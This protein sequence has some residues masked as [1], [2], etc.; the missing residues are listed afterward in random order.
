MKKKIFLSI[1]LLTLI[2][3]GDS[4]YSAKN[5]LHKL[6]EDRAKR[7][8]MMRQKEYNL[9]YNNKKNFL[10]SFAKF[11]S[12]STPVIEGY[13][14]NNRT[15][16]IN[17]VMP[18]YK[19]LYPEQVEEIHFFKKPAISFV[20]FANLKVYNVNVS[21]AR[22]DILWVDT[23]FTPSTHFYV[24]RL[25]PGFRAT[26][27]IIYKD[28]LLGSIS[29]GM[30]EVFKKM[31]ERLHSEVAIYLKD[32]NLKN[33]L[34]PSRYNQFQKYP[35]ID[36]FRVIGEPMDISFKN[37]KKYVLKNNYVYTKIK[38]TDF[39]NNTFA[40][41]VIKDD[42]S[43]DISTIKSHIRNDIFVAIINNLIILAIVLFLFRWMFSK[44]GELH[45]ILT[46]IK[47]QQFSKI[48]KK[49]EEKDE[50]DRYKNQIIDLA[51]DL[52]TYI[53]ILTEKAQKYEIK[54]YKDGLTNTFNRAFLE[55]KAKELFLK[56]QLSKIPVGIMM[57]DIDDFKKINDTYGHDVGDFV[58]VNLANTVQKLI[59]KDDIFIRYGG[60][61]F[62]LILEDSNIVNTK[63]V[64]EKIRKTI[65]NLSI[66]INDKKINFTISIG[67]TDIYET[68]KSIYE[69]IKR[70]DINLY[71]AKKAGK[72]RVEL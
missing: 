25:Y 48:P 52:K 18:L 26:Y 27:P 9:I 3:I 24:C 38:T 21:K 22:A 12:S 1:F 43:K 44:I 6:I 49:V 14:E 62:L 29:F 40:Y 46:Y 35:L 23:S 33:F 10:D 72:N 51:E 53:N 54:A 61:E 4:I 30:I 45:R 67:I 7:I 42:I 64:A 16:I 2:I 11:L 63:N 70:A 66:E 28:R 17:F 31:F 56:Y 68:D 50:C 69:A 5:S 41:I 36:G 20:N 65:E 37:N 57:I 60:E 71:K 15:K 8:S 19:N 58:L 34:L 55:D 47:E 13:L 39:F 59:R 32:S